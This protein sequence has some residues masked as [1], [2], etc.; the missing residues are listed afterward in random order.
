MTP[1]SGPAGA[2]ATGTPPGR[3]RRRWLSR[4]VTGEA[5][6]GTAWVLAAAAL[7]TSFLA[8]AAPRELTATSTVAL[9]RT[10]AGLSGQ[11]TGILIGTQWQPLRGRAANL[12]TPGDITDLA[13]EVGTPMRPPLSSAAAQRWGGFA[14]NPVAVANPAPSA[15][16][17][18]PPTLE[19]AYRSSLATHSRL[20]TGA[21]PG[22]A[23]VAAGIT[24][25][26][27]AVTPAVAARFSLRVGS[28]IV[29]VTQLRLRVTGV[30]D[31]V[32]AGLPY[33]S[34]DP[35]PAAPNLEGGNGNTHWV[36]GVF[37]GPAELIAFQ[38]AV[39]GQ[40]V[41]GTSFLPLATRAI[42]PASLPA[43][44]AG[45][46]A[47]TNANLP[48]GIGPVVGPKNHRVQFAF[49][50]QPAVN[51]SM[52]AAVSGFLAQQHSS[53][54]IGA[55]IVA[56]L[57]VAGLILLL[58]CAR[59]TVDAYSAELTLLRARGGSTRQAGTRVL[60]RAALITGPS[61]AVGGALAVVAVPARGT[62]LPWLPWLIVAA[63]AACLPALL[64]AWTH[65]R[66]RLPGGSD[67]DQLTTARRSPRRTVA[68]LT[69]LVLAAGALVALRLQGSTGQADAY[70]SASPV[71]AAIVASL[72]AARIYPLPVR[73]LLRVAAGRRGPVSFLGL[74]QAAR[75]RRG[76]A[77]PALALVL[78]LT[79]AAFAAML[80]MSVADGQQAASWRQVGADASVQAAG[81]NVISGRA[82]RA[83]AAVPG[84]SRVAA[85][86]TASS[87]GPFGAQLQVG[88]GAARTTGLAVVNPGQYAA[89]AATT[90]WPAFPAGLLRR[91]GATGG[92]VP[93]L[94]SRGLAAGLGR[95]GGR[96]SGVLELDGINLRV[97]VRGIIGTTAAMPG[98]GAFV[99]LP[100][101]AASRLPSIPGP[102]V[103]LAT[104]SGTD[105]RQFRAASAATV[106]GG[107]LTLR[108]QVL[109]G[110]RN[111]PA[112]AA[113]DQIDTLGMWAAA[114]LAV[115]AILLGLATSSASRA[116][117]ARRM[118]ALGMAARQAR[119]L[120]LT[121]TLP[122]LAIGI[123]G[124][125][126]AAVGLALLI[127]PALNLATLAAGTGFV[128]VR[129]HLDALALPAAGAVVV[130]LIVVAAQNALAT[131][132]DPAS[133][134]RPEEAS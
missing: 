107:Q 59:L 126:T 113:T 19:V 125:L 14:I 3:R 99:V 70:T 21:L 45:V 120:A 30:V 110:L 23:T 116:A 74:A 56:G 115:I 31:P 47:V 58:V 9:D 76:A 18:L 61:A 86:Y 43:M 129:P 105:A 79:M 117:V 103:L 5:G 49:A 114:G 127:G 132:R 1:A 38:D 26:G 16:A 29:L 101:W 65:R 82:R 50:Q 111:S 41:Q 91:G 48:A 35:L 8:T 75:T 130:A 53:S 15:R 42:T 122:L 13:S 88:R 27:V 123:V 69:V 68:E 40:F 39:S 100:T 28:V 12:I 63:V 7:L 133:A 46:S 134:L 55:L 94:V 87:S 121:E 84:V 72:L 73:S 92:P 104:G 108:Q 102:D 98:G 54:A 10:V 106:P 4:M 112:P 119:A 25:L 109:S 78:T 96:G 66:A 22:R 81:N 24:T 71:L 33:W 95:A 57:L 11:A 90:P 118:L 67:R 6:P 85:V 36:A 17:A 52:A 89:L 2:R 64:A 51:S 131:R 62:P 20:V 32:D 93:V 128:P 83:L 34:I 97:A 44:L 60:G 80:S 77:L 124:M 37:V